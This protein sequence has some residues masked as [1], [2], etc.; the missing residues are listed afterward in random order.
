MQDYPLF[1]RLSALPAVRGRGFVAEI[2]IDGRAIA[3]EA[4]DGDWWI[5]GVELGDVGEGGRS[6]AE[7][8][9]GFKGSV[10]EILFDFAKSAESFDDFRA[11]VAEFASYVDTEDEGRWVAAREAVRSGVVGEAVTLAREPGEREFRFA[12]T[13]LDASAANAT[14]EENRPDALLAAA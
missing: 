1:F 13:R 3:R 4:A 9:A 6:L 12:I 10:I 14:P 11:A 5:D 8:Y 2:R 7:A